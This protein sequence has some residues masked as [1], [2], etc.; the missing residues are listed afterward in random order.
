MKFDDDISHDLQ[1]RIGTVIDDLKNLEII[2]EL[3]K[4][5]YSLVK[6]PVDLG[7]FSWQLKGIVE[8]LE[9][10]REFVWFINKRE[11]LSKKTEESK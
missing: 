1:D 3:E 10:I 8:T 6:P 2:K 5:D 11:E 7:S 4:I 9:E